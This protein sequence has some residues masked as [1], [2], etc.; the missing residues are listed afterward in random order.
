ML[1]EEP[2]LEKLGGD[3]GVGPGGQGGLHPTMA[4]GARLSLEKDAAQLAAR[5][6]GLHAALVGRFVVRVQ[7]FK[8]LVGLVGSQSGKNLV[9]S[10]K[11]EIVVAGPAAAVDAAAGPPL[12]EMRA[13]ESSRARSPLASDSAGMDDPVQAMKR[14]ATFLAASCILPLAESAPDP[15]A[16][17]PTSGDEISIRIADPEDEAWDV[18]TSWATEK[19]RTYLL[20]AR[21]PGEPWEPFSE[22]FEG[23]G[24]PIDVLDRVERTDPPITLRLVS[25]PIG[26][27]E[28][29]ALRK[30]ARL[31]LTISIDEA[32]ARPEVRLEFTADPAH[33][34]LIQSSDDLI[35]WFARITISEPVPTEIEITDPSSRP[36]QF[37]HYR[38]I[39]LPPTRETPQPA[40]GGAGTAA[41]TRRSATMEPAKG[42]STTNTRSGAQ[43]TD[44]QSPDPEHTVHK[45][46]RSLRFIIH[47]Q[48]V[49]AG[50]HY[51]IIEIGSVSEMG[52][53]VA[54]TD[55]GH[56]LLALNRPD[57]T[58]AMI[59]WIPTDTYNISELTGVY[60]HKVL[61]MDESS[62][63]VG[64]ILEDGV[65]KLTGF[66]YT[67]RAGKPPVL[68][69]LS[70]EEIQA[71]KLE[72][73]V[74]VFE[75]EINIGG[76]RLKARP[77]GRRVNE[78][79]I[80]S[81]PL[82]P[83]SEE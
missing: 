64:T 9:G 63:V 66:R 28:E 15:A 39:E 61:D 48:R 62:A 68:V 53:P 27:P 73:Y 83:V 36:G 37:R 72:T 16:D 76:K 21:R 78:H 17:F 56:M 8:N 74:P 24:K 25:H 29:P 45:V 40:T 49:P 59:L 33:S 19:G 30:T 57:G 81:T 32:D 11:T 31:S 44:A 42:G 58:Q 3:V 26:A 46:I 14:F 71:Y 69:P 34:Y 12:C 79:G 1:A 6:S 4:V 35:F 51:A 22:P 55:A 70:D 2:R 38:L 82:D 52:T 50:R 10:Q 54:I 5:C 67:P 47:E 80:P 43:P 65:E 23:D 75:G 60:F 77:G 7:G 13:P 20:E 41:S 18:V